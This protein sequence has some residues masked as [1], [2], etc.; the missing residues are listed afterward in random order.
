MLLEQC[1]HKP[2]EKGRFRREIVLEDSDLFALEKATQTVVKSAAT[3][4]WRIQRYR[5]L[6]A[7]QICHH[8]LVAH[9]TTNMR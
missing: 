3:N 5:S 6:I 9:I 2:S 8:Q 7:H 4:S 1:L